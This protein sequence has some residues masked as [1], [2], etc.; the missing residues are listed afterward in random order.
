MLMGIAYRV[1][2]DPNDLLV[3]IMRSRVLVEL[4]YGI[5]FESLHCMNLSGMYTNAG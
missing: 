4:T 3:L 5:V 1:E 2:L